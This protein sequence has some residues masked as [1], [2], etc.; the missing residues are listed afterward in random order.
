[1]ETSELM[2]LFHTQEVTGSGPV[3]PTIN[4]SAFNEWFGPAGL[5]YPLEILL[6]EQQALSK[7]ATNEP[8]G[9]PI[10]RESSIRGQNCPFFR[11]RRASR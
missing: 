7:C 6:S 2:I 3:A 8:H 5:Q 1:M 9:A 4:L 11:C 10:L